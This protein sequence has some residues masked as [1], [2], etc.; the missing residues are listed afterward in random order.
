MSFD[1]SHDNLSAL[2]AKWMQRPA[3]ANGCGCHIG[4]VEVGHLYNGE[5]ADAWGHRWEWEYCG[6]SVL[7]EVKV[8]RSDFLADSKKP[9]RN[10]ET[11]GIGDFRYYMCPEGLIK[12]DDL[13]PRW[14]LIWVNKRGHIKV[15]CG[16]AIAFKNHN[17]DGVEYW[18]HEVNHGI[19]KSLLS[20]LLRRLGDP[21]EINI[22]FKK[23]SKIEAD[24]E[25]V[26]NELKKY[27]RDSDYYKMRWE[28]CK[29]L[30]RG[31][32]LS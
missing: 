13:P 1:M 17:K 18:R 32:N 16:H 11:L 3:S 24:Y 2:A 23:A 12:I 21:E 25:R 9:H 30:I 28:K 5:R 8:S 15:L 27:K 19:E 10:G 22:K 6:G 4:L 20:H 14:G 31:N 26:S 7:V 29:E